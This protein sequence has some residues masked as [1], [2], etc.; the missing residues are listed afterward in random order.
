MVPFTLLISS[1]LC[2]PALAAPATTGGDSNLHRDLLLVQSFKKQIT[3]DPHGYTRNWTGNDVCKFGGFSCA[4][5]PNT[6]LKA[7]SGIDLNNFELE[8]NPLKLEGFLDKLTDLTFF[9][10]NT[11]GFT[12]ELPK[13]LSALK[14]LWELDLSSNRLSGPFP[15]AVLNANLVFLDLR[16]NGF[17]GPLPEKLFELDLDTIFLNDNKFG[18]SIPATIG[19]TPARYITLA[20]NRFKGQI[21]ET[22]G[23]AK[24]LEEILLLGNR[25][26]GPLPTVYNTE[27]LT[28]FDVSNNKL[29]GPVPEALCELKKVQLVNLTNNNFDGALGPACAKLVENDVLDV[30]NNCIKGAK[31]QKSAS[32]CTK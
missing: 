30:S 15:E 19:S 22:L 2:A 25:L 11:N 24:S 31:G 10:A 9:H 26:S 8:G 16:F 6:G 23:N 4:D 32:D 1:L 7:L 21:P 28:V 12:G 5:N 17:D 14:W 3:S 18:G 29:S 27:N 20:N 13:D